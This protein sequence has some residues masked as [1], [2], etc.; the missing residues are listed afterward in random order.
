MP[1]EMQGLVPGMLVFGKG[2]LVAS[3]NFRRQGPLAPG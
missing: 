2:F 3:S 1:I